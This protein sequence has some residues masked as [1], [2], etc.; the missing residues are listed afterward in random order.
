MFY[1]VVI[2][3]PTGLNAWAVAPIALEISDVVNKVE[4]EE[5]SFYEHINSYDEWKTISNKILESARAL[6][7]ALQS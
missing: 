2:D 5:K 7:S 3:L 6:N 4:G 1:V